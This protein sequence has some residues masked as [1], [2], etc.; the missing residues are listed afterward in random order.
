VF[1]RLTL[2]PAFRALTIAAAFA[3][4]AACSS[5]G[6]GGGGATLRVTDGV[7]EITADDLKF[8]GSTIEAPAGEPFVVRF[9][10]LESQPHNFA[11]DRSQGGAEIVTGEIITGPDATAEVEVPALEPGEYFFVCDV[12]ATEMT[13]TIVVGEAPPASG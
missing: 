7:V 6:G 10:N 9:T 13:G 1:T 11:V 2:M 4:V 8:N 3:L 12:H 5:G